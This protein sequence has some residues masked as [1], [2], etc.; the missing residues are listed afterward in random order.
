MT[1]QDSGLAQ[2]PGRTIASRPRATTRGPASRRDD[3]PADAEV[4]RHPD[5]ADE[6]LHEGIHDPAIRPAPS[7]GDRAPER[8]L[9]APIHGAP[10]RPPD[11][12]L[13]TTRSGQLADQAAPR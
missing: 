13:V 4:I 7:P 1:H 12:G 6:P 9:G 10:R 3:A 8:A 11:L 5:A 2:T